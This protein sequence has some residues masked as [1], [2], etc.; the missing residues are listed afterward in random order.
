MSTPYLHVSKIGNEWRA[1]VKYPGDQEQ[2]IGARGNSPEQAIE[3]LRQM[4][5]STVTTDVRIDDGKI[6]GG[7]LNGMTMDEVRADRDTFNRLCGE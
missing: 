2:A 3:R 1:V 7:V 5:G 4:Y 6:V